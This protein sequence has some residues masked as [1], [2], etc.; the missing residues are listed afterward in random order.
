MDFKKISHKQTQPVKDHNFAQDLYEP[1]VGF[2]LKREI[3]FVTLASI[4]GGVI[5]HLPSIL[6]DS[7]DNFSQYRIALL[8]NASLVNSNLPEVGFALHMA[9]ATSIGIVTGVFLHKVIKFNIS[10]IRKGVAYG[11]FAGFIVFVVFA[12]PVSQLLLGPSRAEVL[13]GLDP[14]MVL[15]ESMVQTEQNIV[16]GILYSIFIHVIWGF[17]V[18]IVSSLLTQKL[19]TN[20]RCRRCDIEFSRLNTYE[21][22]ITYVHENPSPAMKKIVILGG[23]FAGVYVL[24]KIQKYFEN[25][26]D[27]SIRII[28]QDNF[29]LHT[30]MLPELATGRVEARHIATPIR[31]FCKRARFHHAKVDSIDFENKTV[32]THDPDK[33]SPGENMHNFE[34][35]YLVLAMGGANNFFGNQSVQKHCLT[36]K[37]LEDAL[38]IRDHIIT[39][40]EKAD[41]IE[42]STAKSNLATF[43]VV[44]GGFSGVEIVGEI[45]DF[46]K[47]SV[48][49][50]YRNINP[51]NIRIILVSSSDVILPEIGDLG[52]FAKESLVK[53]GV[54]IISNTKLVD[55]TD[56]MAILNNGMS[57]PTKT[58]IWAAGVTGNP[59]ITN[60]NIQN[61]DK[62]GRIKVDP[63]LRSLDYPEVFA[64]GDCA[65]ITDTKT[66]KPYP[67]T[68]QHAIRQAYT[69]ANNLIASVIAPA[70]QSGENTAT[71][72]TRLKSFDYVA[73]GSMAEIGNRNGVALLFGFQVKGF[74][75]WLIWKQYYLS[76]LPLAEKRIRVAIDWFVDLFVSSD[77][78]KVTSKK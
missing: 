50:Y 37:S 11:L 8:V 39:L 67:P 12:I 7:G 69:A 5:M 19:G 10:Q 21:D 65:S 32:T 25:S 23:G 70:S 30:P 63:H 46:V 38:Y 31:A 60:S 54:N 29:F 36:I 26:V 57:I 14:N 66:G 42:D 58:V 53:E 44:G 34:Y 56:E 35:D 2:S 6:L 4:L 40:L 28:S 24:K 17:T 48:E 33:L 62:G 78:T 74:L 9:V 73:K 18:G 1:R 22:H 76:A 27:T 77:V 59:V 68:A 51:K 45:N 16:S 13:A 71:T 3:F 64:L 61:R 72:T 49:K 15:D 20:Y 43:V 55:V 41:Q 52:G 75:A 47:Y